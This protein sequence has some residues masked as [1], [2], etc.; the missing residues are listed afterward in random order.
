[1]EQKNLIILSRYLSNECAEEEKKAVEKWI[2]S[3][4]ENKQLLKLMETIWQVQEI[5]VQNSDVKTLWNEVAEKAGISAQMKDQTEK[6]VNTIKWPPSLPTNVF[7][8]LRY[9]AILLIIILTPYFIYNGFSIPAWI[10]FNP[11]LTT[12]NVKKGDRQKIRLSDGST[13]VLDAG[14]ILKYHEQFDNDVREV[15]LNG[16]GYFE[17]MPSLEKPF[18]VHAGDAVIQVLGTKFN[19]RA[20]QKY[21][22]VQ[23]AVAEGKVSFNLQKGATKEAV[24]LTPGFSSIVSEN[25]SPSQP[26]KIDIEKYLGWMFN[27]VIFDDT[28]LNEILF[29]LERW[30]DLQFVLADSSYGNERLTLYIQSKSVKDILELIATLTDLQYVYTGKTVRFEAKK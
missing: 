20:W 2:A 24:I 15:F 3:N 16:E 1:M 6:S 28:P 8:I 9:A 13:I 12:V 14:S 10:Q 21:K 7:K 23:V 11:Q 19:V 26:Q 17:V 4:P 5:P 18:I 30:Y 27:E 22:R 29:Q 25:R